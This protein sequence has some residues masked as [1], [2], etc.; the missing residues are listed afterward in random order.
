MHTNQTDTSEQSPQKKVIKLHRR[1]LHHKA[2]NKFQNPGKEP[3]H[4]PIHYT[5]N[6]ESN[7]AS[8]CRAIARTYERNYGRR[9]TKSERND[10]VAHCGSKKHSNHRSSK[11]HTLFPEQGD[12][13][14]S[15]AL[16]TQFPIPPD[17]VERPAGSTFRCLIPPPDHQ[18]E[19][20]S[21]SSF[22][23]LPSD[24]LA[25]RKCGNQLFVSSKRNDRGNA[26]HSF[27]GSTKAPSTFP[28]FLL[29]RRSPVLS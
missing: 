9:R 17:L 26:T 4:T 13:A 22:F 7:S 1:T 24:S 18:M 6:E 28:T 3:N 25:R 16:V 14:S 21:R 10:L 5:C 8:K 20:P 19:R 2:Q 23:I 15:P 27:A 12:R 11:V 29:L